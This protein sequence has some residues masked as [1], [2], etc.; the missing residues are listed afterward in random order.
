VDTTPLQ[1]RRHAEHC[2]TLANSQIDE[3]TRLILTTMADEFDLQASAAKAKA[4]LG[5]G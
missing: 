2:R 1:L 5:A 4:K 3:R